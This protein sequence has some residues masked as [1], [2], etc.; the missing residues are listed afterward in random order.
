ME[1]L[2]RIFYKCYRKS[3]SGNF[4]YHRQFRYPKNKKYRF[5][6]QLSTCFIHRM[7]EDRGCFFYFY[8]LSSIFRYRGICERRFSPK[9]SL[10]R[11]ENIG[12]E[13]E[14]GAWG[15][16]DFRFRRFIR[17]AL[18]EFPASLR[19]TPILGLRV[20]EFRALVWRW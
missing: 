18:L 8:I 13:R 3:N 11:A 10:L 12:R 15:K 2:Y 19:A 1:Q 17:V 7:K 14:R 4:S 6:G 20:C 9:I 16:S 5:S